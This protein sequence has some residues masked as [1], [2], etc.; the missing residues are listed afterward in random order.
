[1]YTALGEH[2]HFKPVQR[3]SDLLVLARLYEPVLKYAAELEIGALDEDEELCSPKVDVG[4][5]NAA[6]LEKDHRYAS[7]KA[8][9]ERIGCRIL[10]QRAR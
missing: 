8:S 1:M 9:G 3:A 4:C 7:I 10:R 5:I 6:G 2:S